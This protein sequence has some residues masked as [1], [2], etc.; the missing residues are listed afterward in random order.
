MLVFIIHIPS[1]VFFYSGKYNCGRWPRINKY[2]LI[3]AVY[4]AT[5]MVSY[6][7]NCYEVIRECVAD[8]KRLPPERG[9]IKMQSKKSLLRLMFLMQAT[10][11]EFASMLTLTYPRF[12]PLDGLIVKQD[13]AAVVQKLRRSGWEYLWFLEFQKRGAPHVHILTDQRA[14]TPRMRVD[15]GLYW[16]TRIALSDWF[17]ALCPEEAYNQEVIKMAKFN[18]HYKTWGFMKSREGARNYVTK[19]ASKERQK[20]VPPRYFNV[21]RFWGSTRA[22]RPPGIEFDITEADIEQWLVDHGHPAQDYFLVPKFLWGAVPV[23]TSVRKTL[24]PAA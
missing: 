15:Y 11:V 8:T 16:T 21:G 5:K 3:R 14:I 18:T 22:L 19:Y 2:D 17:I 9:K 24:D 6:G 23:D 12:Y 4:P 1:N 13:V 7:N 20:T 10:H